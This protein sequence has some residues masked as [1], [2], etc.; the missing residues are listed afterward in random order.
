MKYK[1]DDESDVSKCKC[2]VAGK[3]FEEG[4]AARLAGAS[5]AVKALIF[6]PS[7]VRARQGV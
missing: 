2:V 5:D 1:P 3:T 4:A 7:D 6:F